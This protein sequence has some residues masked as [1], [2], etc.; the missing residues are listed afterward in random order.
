MVGDDIVVTVLE[1]RGETVRLGVQAPRS[2]PVHR[3]EVFDQVQRANQAAASTPLDLDSA[4]GAVAAE[5]TRRR[6][7]P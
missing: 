2:V 6:P 3:E 1:V 4:L 7:R 5:R